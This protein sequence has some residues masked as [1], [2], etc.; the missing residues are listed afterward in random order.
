MTDFD[1]AENPGAGADHDAVSDFRMTISAFFAG[2]AERNIVQHRH[3]V[4]DDGCLTHDKA[5]GMVEE[6]AT[7]DLRR[8]MDVALKH[9]R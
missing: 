3:V 1:I 8:G 5:S 6:N 4:L 2:A 9:C 7:A